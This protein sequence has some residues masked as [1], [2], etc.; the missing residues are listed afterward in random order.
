[1]DFLN[2]KTVNRKHMATS[3]VTLDVNGDLQPLAS[4]TSV[5]QS[6]KIVSKVTFWNWLL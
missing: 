2:D 6:Q 4:K 3:E 1:M 5:I